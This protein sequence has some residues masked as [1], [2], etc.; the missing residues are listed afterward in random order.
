MVLD[1]EYHRDLASGI[2]TPLDTRLV[3]RD[4]DWG[5]LTQAHDAAHDAASRFIEGYRYR[6]PTES[7]LWVVRIPGGYAIVPN[8]MYSPN[9]PWIEAVSWANEREQTRGTK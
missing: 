9:L 3:W 1:H 2:S 8:S 5:G 4:D 6:Y 7:P